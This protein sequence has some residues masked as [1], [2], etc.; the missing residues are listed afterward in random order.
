VEDWAM[1]DYLRNTD[2]GNF[3]DK[4]LRSKQRK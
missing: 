3:S 2:M 1:Y 4:Y